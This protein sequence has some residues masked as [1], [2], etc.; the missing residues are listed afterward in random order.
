MELENFKH[1]TVNVVINHVDGLVSTIKLQVL[2]NNLLSSLK[3]IIHFWKQQNKTLAPFNVK[4]FQIPVIL[5]YLKYEHYKLKNDGKML[6]PI[7]PMCNQRG[8][9]LI[10]EQGYKFITSPSARQTCF[11]MLYVDPISC[12][13]WENRVNMINSGR[14]LGRNL[15]KLRKKESSILKKIF[16]ENFFNPVIPHMLDPDYDNFVFKTGVYFLQVENAKSTTVRLKKSYFHNISFLIDLL[17][18]DRGG[19]PTLTVLGFCTEIYC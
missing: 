4:P 19:G 16:P 17:W 6:F 13:D 2:S 9:K 7:S 10:D 11:L 5:L 3:L 12:N 14:N 1:C 18:T 15:K 8:V